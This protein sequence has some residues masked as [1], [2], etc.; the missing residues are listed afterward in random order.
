MPNIEERICI[1]RIVPRTQTTKTLR[2][3]SM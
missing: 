2:S 3:K 1:A